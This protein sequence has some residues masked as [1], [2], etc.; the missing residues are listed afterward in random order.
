V[1]L[2]AANGIDWVSAYLGILWA[3]AVANPVNILNTVEEVAFIAGDCGARLLLIEADRL[4]E[5]A[6]RSDRAVPA[7][8]SPR[9]YISPTLVRINE[10]LSRRR[11]S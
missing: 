10:R 2:H 7:D 4:A 9:R 5:Y 6:A 8:D 3:G 11:M 1:T